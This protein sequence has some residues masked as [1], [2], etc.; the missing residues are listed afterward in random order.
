MQNDQYGV[1]F[2]VSCFISFVS[3]RTCHRGNRSQKHLTDAPPHLDAPR[4]DGSGSI[5]FEEL[6]TAL[7][8]LGLDTS[9]KDVNAFIKMG[10]DD[11]D[12]MGDD[13]HYQVEYDEFLGMM[14]KM[15]QDKSPEDDRDE[16]REV[17][18]KEGMEGAGRGRR[19]L[20]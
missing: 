6:T 12:A 10:D 16:G 1:R 9:E 4:K 8:T 19:G 15:M 13:S 3:S 20:G 5:S 17:E 18:V 14:K 7:E 2:N 11:E